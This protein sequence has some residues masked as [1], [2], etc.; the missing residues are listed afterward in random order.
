M[1]KISTIRGAYTVKSLIPLFVLFLTDSALIGMEKSHN[2]YFQTNFDDHDRITSLLYSLISGLCRAEDDYIEF[3]DY[4]NKKS[5][6]I[7]FTQANNVLAVCDQVPAISF[8]SCA[9][10]NR[11]FEKKSE[12]VH[13][14]IVALKNLT[15][16]DIKIAQILQYKVF[17]GSS[18][19]EMSKPNDRKIAQNRRALFNAISFGDSAGVNKA[20]IAKLTKNPVLTIPE[21]VKKTIIQLELGDFTFLG[22]SMK[23]L[24]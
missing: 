9:L 8:L 16:E 15:P 21:L 2:T 3:R 7:P 11:S 14:V 5:R 12:Y 4:R 18:D 19:L 1:S 13:A 24:K 17:H 10:Y 22:D 20:S 6:H 23:T